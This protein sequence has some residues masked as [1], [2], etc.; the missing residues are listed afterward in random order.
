MAKLSQ[1]K[2]VDNMRLHHIGII[3]DD[4]L[5]DVTVYE[6]LGYS[7]IAENGEVVVNDEVQRNR[8]A[9]MRHKESGELVELIEPM[10]GKSSVA[11][12]KKG[13]AHLC[14]E[15][16]NLEIVL[17]EIKRRRLG[18]VFTDTLTAPALG[19]GRVVFVFLKNGAVIEFFEPKVL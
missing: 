17:A 13:L 18:V 8:L 19:N 14:Y 6:Y 15:V 5:Q 4:I 11:S 2:P 12:A 7:P 16:D 9:F 1:R 10:D 3:T